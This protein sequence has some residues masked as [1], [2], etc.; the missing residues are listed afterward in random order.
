MIREPWQSV[1]ALCPELYN[2]AMLSGDVENACICRWSFCSGGFWTASLD[3]FSASKLTVVCIKEV[4]S[5]N[6]LNNSIVFEFFMG[7]HQ[8]LP[9]LSTFIARPSI[10][11]ILCYIALW[12]CIMLAYI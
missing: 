8:L 11:R 2:S 7:S 10:N 1:V 9:S 4:V 3:L 5:L 12:H 6:H